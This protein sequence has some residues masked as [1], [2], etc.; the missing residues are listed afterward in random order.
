MA[1]ALVQEARNDTGTGTPITVTLSA[2]PQDQS[3]LILIARCDVAAGVT[4]V[5][6]GVGTGTWAVVRHY[7]QNSTSDIWVGTVVGTGTAAV[8]VTFAAGVTTTRAYLSEWSGLTATTDLAAVVASGVGTTATTASYGSTLNALDLLIAD[9]VSGSTTP[10]GYT[11]GFTALT[12]SGR[13]GMAYLITSATGTFSVSA[14]VATPWDTILV[15][16]K[17]AVAAPTG[18]A[19]DTPFVSMGQVTQW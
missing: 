3:V 12:G 4:G 18:S 6:G 8:Q 11:N 16:F 14:T 19:F 5:T 13:N 1:I 10:S 9:F 7:S 2:V 17:A 15:G